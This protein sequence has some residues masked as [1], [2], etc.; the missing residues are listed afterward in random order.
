MSSRASRRAVPT[1]RPRRAGAVRGRVR[2]GGKARS[3]G[4]QAPRPGGGAG[5][6]ASVGHYAGADRAPREEGSARQPELSRSGMT[7][8]S[9]HKWGGGPRGTKKEAA[10][11]R[12]LQNIKLPVR[13]GHRARRA[14]L[15]TMERGVAKPRKTDEHHR[16]SRGLRHTA[17]L[18]HRWARHVE[19]E[20][21]RGRACGK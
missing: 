1:Q 2:R 16:P 13:S 17:G 8:P 12:P 3:V 20:C 10:R 4:N 14:I 7:V 5:Q 15:S 19:L 21:V 18:R 6:R 9:R 11:R